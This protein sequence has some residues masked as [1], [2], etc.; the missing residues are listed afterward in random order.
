M[1]KDELRVVQFTITKKV[2]KKK[3]KKKE[4]KKFKKLG[5]FHLWGREEDKKG[6]EIFFALVEEL[7]TGNVIEVASKNI[8]F[9]SDDEIEAITSDEGVFEKIEIEEELEESEEELVDEKSEEEK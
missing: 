6:K 2:E 1:Y 5:L 7:E 4:S 9:L 3:S 8:R